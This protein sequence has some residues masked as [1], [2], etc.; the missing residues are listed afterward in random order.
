MKLIEGDDKVR[1][2]K[3]YQEVQRVLDLYDCVLLPELKIVGGQPQHMVHIAPKPREV[4][5]GAKLAMP[6][7]MTPK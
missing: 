5:Q 3:C 6:K 4:S 2:Q 7:G 1:A